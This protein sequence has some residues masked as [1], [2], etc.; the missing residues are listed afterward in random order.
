M[1]RLDLP[2]LWLLLGLL[3]AWALARLD[4]W[5]LSF[6]GACAD[7]V[8]GLG[9]GGGLLLILVAVVQMRRHRTAVLPHREAS[10]LLTTG[11]FRRSRNPIY[12]GMAL[13]LLGW[14]F[15]VDEP[16]ALPL[17]PAFV[18]I[19]ER[20]FILPEEAMLRRRFGPGFGRYEAAT[21]R[22]L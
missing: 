18:W 4:P 14:I 16:L 12:L 22:W 2:P 7:F 19:I 21:R 11:V 5:G 8:A 1:R 20:R 13:V 6:G 17:V 9:I 10:T 15:R 3:L